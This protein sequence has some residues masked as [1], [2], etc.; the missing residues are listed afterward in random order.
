[1]VSSMRCELNGLRHTREN[2]R[3]CMGMARGWGQVLI[4]GGDRLGLEASACVE[5]DQREELYGVRAMRYGWTGGV[6]CFLP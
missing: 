3:R 5:P 1:M 6:M 4:S 2:G